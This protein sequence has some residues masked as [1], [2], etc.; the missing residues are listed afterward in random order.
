MSFFGDVL[1]SIGSAASGAFD[2]VKAPFNFIGDVFSNPDTIPDLMTGGAVSNNK[3]IQAVNAQ[4]IAFAQKQTDFQ[5][6]MSNTAYQRAMTDM[7]AGGLNP[8]LAYSQGGASVP[9]GVSPQLQA[10]RPGD[11]NS[12]LLSTAK[13]IMSFGVGLSNTQADTRQKESTTALNN[14]NHEVALNQAEKTAATA[15]E[16]MASTQLI[17][18]QTKKAKAET[19]LAQTRASKERADLPRA[20]KQSEFDSKAVMYDSIMDRATQVLGAI[21]SGRNALARRGGQSLTPP[22][23]KEANEVLRRDLQKQMRN[24]RD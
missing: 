5:E 10:G 20:T 6:R 23:V 8:M 11:V 15:K 18:E 14:A 12:G 19:D 22:S 4:N 1:G 3:A 16:S 9:T 7:K 24:R 17:N 2:V 13:D 21:T